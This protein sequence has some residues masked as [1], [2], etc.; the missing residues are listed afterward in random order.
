[1]FSTRRA[2]FGELGA[3]FAPLARDLTADESPRD[4]WSAQELLQPEALARLVGSRSE[5]LAI[6][7]VAFAVLYRQK[8]IVGAKF[9]GP[10]SKADGITA[11]KQAVEPLPHNAAIILYCGCCPMVHCPNIRPAFQTLKEL[12]Y[13]N[14]RVLNLASSFRADWQDKGYPVSSQS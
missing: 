14:V 13:T 5:R 6:I 2:F 11:L 7:C 4:P 12:G 10:A 8:H 3:L 1:M 9:A